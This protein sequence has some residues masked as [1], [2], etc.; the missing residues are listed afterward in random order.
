MSTPAPISRSQKDLLARLI[1]QGRTTPE[2]LR[3]AG[4]AAMSRSELARWLDGLFGN[5]AD[6]AAEDAVDAIFAEAPPV[7]HSTRVES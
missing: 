1:S 6:A 2:Q 7:E 5:T 3:E 4:V